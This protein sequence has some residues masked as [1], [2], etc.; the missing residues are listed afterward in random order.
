MNQIELTARI[1]EGSG[2]GMARKLRAAG[3]VPAVI[4]GPHTEPI[5]I[6]LDFKEVTDLL[7]SGQAL[8]SLVTLKVEGRKDLGKKVMM[9]KEIQRHH[10]RRTPIA[11]DLLEVDPNKPITAQIPLKF[12][13]VALGV[14]E[15]GILQQLVRTLKIVAAPASL[16]DFITA[17]VSTVEAGHTLYLKDIQL[18]PGVVIHGDERTP[19]CTIV[20]PRGIAEEA[21]AEEGEGEEKKEEGEETE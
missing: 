1:R 19:I 7:I 17:D 18:P 10:I 5:S 14:K 15:G 12:T 8:R 9:F 21:K 13:G 2:K 20:I 4:Y 6:S 3:G 16:P 11:A